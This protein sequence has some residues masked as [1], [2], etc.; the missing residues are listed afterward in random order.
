MF[1]GACGMSCFE[2]DTCY[3]VSESKMSWVDALDYCRDI[4]GD[5]ASIHS[6]E[7]NEFLNSMGCYCW[8]GLNDID[9]EGEFVWSDGSDVDFLHW[10]GGE[11]N[12]AGG[13]EHYAHL[14]EK[15]YWNDQDVESFYAFCKMSTPT[16][17]NYTSPAPFNYTS[18]APS[19]GPDDITFNYTSP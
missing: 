15:G 12:N 8:I 2:E 17:F 10:R 18:P 7:E 19:C 16:L 3:R 6:T 1:H 9:N 11:P 14:N 4:S 5:L 13:E